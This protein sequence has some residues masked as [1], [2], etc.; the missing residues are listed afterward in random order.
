MHLVSLP[1]IHSLHITSQPNDTYKFNTNRNTDALRL[2]ILLLVCPTC[3]R[4]ANLSTEF[5]AF[6]K[7]DVTINK[8]ET[9]SRIDRNSE[10]EFT[11]I[12]T[13]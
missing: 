2:Y 6:V 11:T 7:S 9:L 13:Y 3:N 8:T 5:L 10:L 4:R 12:A 1:T